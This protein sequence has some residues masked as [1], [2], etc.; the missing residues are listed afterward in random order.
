MLLS[1]RLGGLSMGSI[2]TAEAVDRLGLSWK[3][4]KCEEF[5]KRHG[6][7]KPG[8]MCP[9]CGTHIDEFGNHNAFRAVKWIIDTFKHAGVHIAEPHAESLFQLARIK[10][11]ESEATYLETVEVALNALRN[12][13]RLPT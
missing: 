7:L 10:S 5:K 8:H 6:L 9:V 13:G 11:R 2:L 12:G 1:G 3:C 4:T